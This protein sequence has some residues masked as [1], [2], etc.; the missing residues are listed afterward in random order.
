M[1]NIEREA[2]E[3]VEDRRVRVETGRGPSGG[4]APRCSG[5]DIEVPCSFFTFHFVTRP[6]R[7]RGVLPDAFAWTGLVDSF[8]QAGFTERAIMR[9]EV[10][11]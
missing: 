3:R 7:H 4:L 6:Y 1:S 11:E 10:S 9:Y 2:R 8:E 5:R